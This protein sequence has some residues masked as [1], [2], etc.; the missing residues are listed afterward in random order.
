[1][2]TTNTQ[3]PGSLERMVRRRLIVDFFNLGPISRWDVC[4]KGRWL[5]ESDLQLHKEAPDQELW[6][7]AFE[8]AEQRGELDIMRKYVDAETP[9]P[10][11]AALRQPRKARHE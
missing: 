6:A 4:D 7:L 10:C 9:K 3:S 2:K 11:L 8:R 1:M 5:T